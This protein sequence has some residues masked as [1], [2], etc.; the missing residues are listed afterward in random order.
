MHVV[1]KFTGDGILAFV[2][3]ALALFGVWRSNRQSV[4]NLQKQIDA[5]KQERQN[6]QREHALSLQTG[7]RAEVRAFMRDVSVAKNYLEGALKKSGFPGLVP[8]LRDKSFPV[9]EAVTPELGTL[10]ESTLDLTV[11]FYLL[12]STFLAFLRKHDELFCL[13]HLNQDPKTT[14]DARKYLNEAFHLVPE[15]EKFGKILVTKLDDDRGEKM[16]G[17]SPDAQT[18]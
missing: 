13:W 4:R 11:G 3:G 2:G 14:E 7:I 18:Y 8:P 12:A 17:G 15:L 16:I 5:E 6:Q 10:D 9:Y 1:W